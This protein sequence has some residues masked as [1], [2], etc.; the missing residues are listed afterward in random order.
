MRLFIA[1]MPV[2]PPIYLLDEIS[3]LKLNKVAEYNLRGEFNR[4]NFYCKHGNQD[5]VIKDCDKVLEL[6]PNNVDAYISCGSAYTNTK[7]LAQRDLNKTIE[8]NPNDFRAYMAR[9]MVYLNIA[10]NNLAL[11][12]TNKAV[13]LNPEIITNFLT[14]IPPKKFS[15]CF[16]TNRK[17]FG[18][19]FS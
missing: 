17:G 8:L 12:D 6:A 7:H 16:S 3:A 9:G 19:H 14:K 13:E 18:N 1:S 5:L 10:Q 15:I 11:E 2:L 4:R